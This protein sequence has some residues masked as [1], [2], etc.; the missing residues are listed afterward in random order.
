MDIHIQLDPN[1][2]KSKSQNPVGFEFGPIHSHEY[3]HP[4]PTSVTSLSP[5]ANPST[6]LSE[7]SRRPATEGR[8][9]PPAAARTYVLD[10]REM[11]MVTIQF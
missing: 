7:Q 11:N 8:G 5:P 6:L 3:T 2:L 10:D 4:T 9:G 1:S